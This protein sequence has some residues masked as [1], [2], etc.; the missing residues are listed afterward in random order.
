MELLLDT[1]RA[2]QSTIA[3]SPV[4]G[5]TLS[6]G[7]FL[8]VALPIGFILYVIFT[9]ADQWRMSER[10]GLGVVAD[11]RFTAGFYALHFCYPDTYAVYVKIKDKLIKMHIDQES[12]DLVSVKNR[13]KVKYVRGRFSKRIYI[14]SYLIS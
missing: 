3:D 13:L 2:L 14:N 12:F 4:F 9:F 11:K 10:D 6:I 5:I 1:I 8:I 7:L